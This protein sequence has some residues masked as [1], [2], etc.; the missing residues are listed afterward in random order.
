M[1]SFSS[2]T[3]TQK[4]LNYIYLNKPAIRP[5][6]LFCD[7]TKDYR[8]PSEPMV[9]DEV[10]IKFRTARR[11]VDF[12]FCICNGERIAMEVTE[13]DHAFEYF[14]TKLPPLKNEKIEYY[15]EIQLGNSYCY[16]NKLGVQTEV[17]PTYNFSIMPGFS[18]PDWAKGAVIYQIFVDRFCNG[19][20]EN[21]EIGRAH[22]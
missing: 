6:A 12:V 15:F 22:V 4:I 13:W 17:N 14:E 10:T 3:N 21:D 20:R 9:G 8:I 16:Y 18:T 2:Y 11:N 19:D 1:G 7:G 5:D